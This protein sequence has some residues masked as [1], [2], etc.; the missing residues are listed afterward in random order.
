MKE[1]YVTPEMNVIT[2]ECIEDIL[3]NSNST[4]FEPSG[5]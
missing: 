1:I 5:E 4:P 2:I 3:N